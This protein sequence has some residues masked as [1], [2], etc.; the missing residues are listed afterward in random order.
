[1]ERLAQA[2]GPASDLFRCCYLT[3]FVITHKPSALCQ[4]GHA[5]TKTE[6]TGLVWNSRSCFPLKWVAPKSQHVVCNRPRSFLHAKG[7]PPADV[8]H[9][10]YFG[11]SFR[12]LRLGP[13]STQPLSCPIIQTSTYILH[14][15][16]RYSA[17]SFNFTLRT[18]STEL[19]EFS[20]RFFFFSYACKDLKRSE[21]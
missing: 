4:P 9:F 17:I 8:A 14:T 10:S 5:G 3:V 6:A 15:S 7:S 12:R 11:G 19:R 20:C 2:P 18:P 1:M 13:P 16:L 21:L